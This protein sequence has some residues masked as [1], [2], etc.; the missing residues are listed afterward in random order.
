[1]NKQKKPTRSGKLDLIYKR[2]KNYFL[3]E[4][5]NS[6][7]STFLITGTAVK[8]L[9][10]SCLVTDLD[11]LTRAFLINLVLAMSFIPLFK[12]RI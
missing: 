10:S 7:M 3:K 11:L 12:L 8:R 2:C 9:M 5:F 6:S 1:M 4:A